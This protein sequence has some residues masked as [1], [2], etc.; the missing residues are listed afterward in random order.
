MASWVL[1]K[2]H[3][4]YKT[5]IYQQLSPPCFSVCISILYI[6]CHAFCFSLPQRYSGFSYPNHTSPSPY[7]LLPT[8]TSPFFSVFRLAVVAF[9]GEQ[10]QSL[11]CLS[12]IRMTGREEGKRAGWNAARCIYSMHL[13][14]WEVVRDSAIH[15]SRFIFS[16]KLLCKSPHLSSVRNNITEFCPCNLFCTLFVLLPVNS[17]LKICTLMSVL[18]ASGLQGVWTVEDCRWR[19]WVVGRYIWLLCWS[20]CRSTSTFIKEDY[21]LVRPVLIPSSTYM[22][23]LSTPLVSLFDALGT[24]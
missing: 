19:F 3:S 22:D 2:R 8:S 14:C 5:I 17:V 11:T 7:Y 6:I 4:L 23:A 1:V 10:I 16:L 12:G 9:H 21:S 24:L 20:Y 13:Y 15:M 18:A